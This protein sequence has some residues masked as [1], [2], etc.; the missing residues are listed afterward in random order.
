MIDSE[1]SQTRTRDEASQ[2]PGD[3][4]VGRIGELSH[5]SANE[6]AV[7]LAYDELEP[8]ITIVRPARPSLTYERVE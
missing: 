4:A 2:C 6:T 7:S 8:I 1:P 5:V 3:E